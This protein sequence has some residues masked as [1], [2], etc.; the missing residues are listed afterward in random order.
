[1]DDPKDVEIEGAEAPSL[2]P[3]RPI[4][5]YPDFDTVIW[6]DMTAY[7]DT[8]HIYPFVTK[9]QEC[10]YRDLHGRLAI[11]RVEWAKAWA[12]TNEG[13][14]RNSTVMDHFSRTFS[15][16]DAR[17]EWN[18]AVNTFEKYDPHGIFSN[19]FLDELLSLK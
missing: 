18:W 6:I 4:P 3:A 14:W 2:S 8:P 17:E 7:K 12:F 13:P 15:S 1:V 16:S 9:L 10:L 5:E 19:A 11:M